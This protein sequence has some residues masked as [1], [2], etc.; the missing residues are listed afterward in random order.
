MGDISQKF[1]L[2]HHTD[3]IETEDGVW[4]IYS[5]RRKSKNELLKLREIE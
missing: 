1:N 2:I 5:W 4:T 3:P